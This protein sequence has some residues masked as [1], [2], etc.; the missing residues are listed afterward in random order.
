MRGPL[1]GAARRGREPQMARNVDL[2]C[3]PEGRLNLICLIEPRK[4]ASNSIFF[5][6]LFAILVLMALGAEIQIFPPFIFHKPD[7]L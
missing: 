5:L 2:I 1:V 7:G 4:E 6:A 3:L